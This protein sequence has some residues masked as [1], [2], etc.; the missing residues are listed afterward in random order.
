MYKAEKQE[1][2][3]CAAYF[4]CACAFFM[5]RQNLVFLLGCV[6]KAPR[7]VKKDDEYLYA[8]VYVNVAR[9]LRD[10]G[11]RRKY[12]KCDNPVIMTRD[13]ACMKEIEK[14]SEHDAVYIKGM[15]ACKKLR[16]ASFCEYCHTKNSLP[17]TLVYVNPI[18]CEKVGHLETDE[19][20]L[21]YLASHRE[22]SNQAYIY[23]TLCRDPKKMV[24]KETNLTIT[25]YQVALNRKFRIRTDPPELKTDYPWVKSYGQNAIEDKKRLHVGSE[26]IVDGCLQAR[27][28]QR[29][30]ICGQEIGDDGKPMFYG[31]G[32]PVLRQD[33]KGNPIGCGKEYTWKDRAMEIVPYDTEYVCNYYDDEEI[34]EN[35]RKRMLQ[36]LGDKARL[37]LSDE[38]GQAGNDDDE[39]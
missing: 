11:D 36:S 21:Q 6:A 14:W 29:H 18:F 8:M 5:A 33:E 25:Q 26:V 35:E 1:R 9:G 2:R 15:L 4:C 28:V 32:E 27:S 10:V 3:Q 12:M 17:G 34:E 7:I 13:P 39:D 31:N 24:S 22:I 37:D 19:E 16:K 20:C 30:A 38:A 23:G